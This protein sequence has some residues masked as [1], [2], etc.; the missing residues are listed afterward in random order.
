MWCKNCNRETLQNTCEICG[1]TTE[2]DIPY[3]IF[4]CTDCKVPLVKCVNSIDKAVCPLCNHETKYLSA[5]IRPVFP[6]ERLLVEILLGKPLEFL[7]SSVWAS[8]NRYYIDGTPVTIALSTYHKHSPEKVRVLIEEHRQHNNY[9]FF[10]HYIELFLDANKT[11]FDY[12]R[13]ETFT[14]INSTAEQ[15]SH[16]CIVISFS[17]GKDST[18]TADLAVR[19]LADPSLVHVFGNTTLEFPLTIEYIQRFRKDNP[20]TILKT[21]QNREQDFYSVC[22]DIGPPAR[23]LRWCCSM[24]KTGPITRTLNSLFKEKNILTFYGIRKCESVSRSKYNRIEDN[25]E[26]VKIQKQKVAS[27]IFFWKDID[28]WLY[29]LSENLDFNDAYRLGYDRVG[30][31]CCPNNNERAQFLSQIYMPDQSS[32]WR[33]FL[34]TFSRRIGKSDAEEYVD[35]GKWKARQGGNGVASSE[36]IKI[37]FTNCTSEENAKVYELNRPMDQALIGLFVPFGNIAT[38]LGRKLINETII[39]DNKTN[40]PILSIQPF[41]HDGYVFSVKVKTM[42]VSKHD[43]L[44]RMV[45]YQ[46][47]KYNACRKCLKCE[48]LCRAGAISLVGDAYSINPKKCVHCKI[49]VTAKYLDGGCTMAKYLRTKE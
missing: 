46:V 16:E 48:S 13:D 4:W 2:S 37:H 12:I 30:C 1:S 8:D 49:C 7:H 25:T 28:I 39:I 5:D 29:I 33:D 21:A 10:N 6:E 32:K 9:Q 27:P 36:D 24:F 43:D 31:W 22:E 44:Q 18:V 26:L 42:N 45:G 23:M 41:S 38:E 20:K 3:E 15:Y 40:V 34:I 14:F 19:A 47:R 35:S 17:G 11:H